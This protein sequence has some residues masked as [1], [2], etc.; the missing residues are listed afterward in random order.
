MRIPDYRNVHGVKDLNHWTTKTSRVEKAQEDG[1]EKELEDSIHKRKSE[2]KTKIEKE[3]Q[4]KHPTLIDES[5]EL[6]KMELEM[7]HLFSENDK[8][9]KSEMNI[10]LDEETP[11]GND[12]FSSWA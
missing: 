2:E 7:G 9:I 4:K 3:A 5:Q 1:F 11:N 8:K 6:G 12:Q 10:D